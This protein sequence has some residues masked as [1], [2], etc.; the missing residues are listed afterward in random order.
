[1]KDEEIKNLLGGFATDTLTDHERELLFTAALKDQELFNALADDQALR[2]FLSD[3]VSRRKIL[4]LLQPEAPSLFDRL[5]QWMRRPAVWA[6]AGGAMAALIAVVV[7]RQSHPPAIELA[8]SLPPA[9]VA[10]APAPITPLPEPMRDEARA[11]R[12]MVVTSQ[13]ASPAIKREIAAAPK[14][15]VA[16]LDFDVGPPPPTKDAEAAS[17]DLGKT[18]SD[19]LGKKLDLSGYAVIDRKEVDKAMQEQK[20]NERQLDASTAASVGRSVGA[21]AV[22]LG[23]V[24][25]RLTSSKTGAAPGGAVGGFRSVAPMAPPPVP[26]AQNVQVTAQVIDTQNAVRLGFAQNAQNAAGLAGAV[27]QVAVS[28][29]QQIQ[30]NARMKMEG[31]VTDV[32]AKILTLNVGAK[33]GVKPGDRLEVRRGSQALGHIAITS[34]QDSFSVGVFDG[35][36]PARIG[37]TVV[38]Q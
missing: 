4:Q 16:V 1:M 34:A 20:V 17:A 31:L 27:D 19:L 8:K 28:L 11:R 22:I 18:T 37:D 33:A 35:P 32:N 9:A 13:P 30:Q 2:D 10:P 12:D 5:T 38:N 24:T 26:A 21:D 23:S 6:I 14:M 25:T 3:P 7:I 36:D 29:K 15:K